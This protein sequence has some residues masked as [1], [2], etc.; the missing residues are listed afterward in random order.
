MRISVLSLHTSPAAQ[1]GQGDAGGMNV[2]VAH[3]V[4]AL[5]A[6]GH[7]VDVFTADPHGLGVAG[8]EQ[9]R[10][11]TLAPNL[12]LHRL[13][14]D[15]DSKDAL[16]GR[17]DDFAR[18][19]TAHPVFTAADLVWAHYWISAEA[20]L[21]AVRTRGGPRPTIIASMHTIGAVKNRDSDTA[22][23]SPRRLRTEERIAAGVDLL[24]ANTP[25]E[26]RDLIGELGADPASVVVARPG[27]DHALFSPG[28][29][30]A[31][32]AELGLAADENLVLYVGR[33]QF[34]KGTDVVVDA[35]ACLHENNP[36]LSARTRGILLGAASGWVEPS[37]RPGTRG[38]GRAGADGRGRTAP[39]REWSTP[40]DFHAT[41]SAAIAAEPNVEV[42]PPVPAAELVTYYRAADVLL[43]PSRSE[44]FGLVA[45]EA[46]A[47]GLPSI[48]AA[49]G[50]LP[51]IVENGYSGLLIADHNPRH[52]ALT[53]ERLLGD[54]ELRVELADHAAARS[55]RFDWN[56]TVAA[57]LD[58]VA[59]EREDSARI[60][61]GIGA[62]SRGMAGDRGARDASDLTAPGVC[63]GWR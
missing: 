32:R 44:S 50:G 14:V 16:A 54:A 48:A 51:E 52:W 29:R 45:A 60:R 49:V 21:R 37:A 8:D 38:A 31:A 33:M 42:R 9:A 61:S 10:S 46:A 39:D 34:I 5:A 41:L 20:A 12:R 7:E 2:Y 28:S 15:A 56:R 23:E 59:G 40:S 24:V 63:G 30:R 6:S 26:R 35:L 53:L 36:E 57:V 22:E 4:R 27:V 19:L 3:T 1:P 55:Q 62:A 47:S 17:L 25:A 18:L 43:V 58:A 13:D 11:V